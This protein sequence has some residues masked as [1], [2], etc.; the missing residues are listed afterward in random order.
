MFFSFP[1]FVQFC[2]LSL[3]LR[4][5][6]PAALNTLS[7][8]QNISPLAITN[9][10]FFL[11]HLSITGFVFFSHQMTLEIA[12]F[13]LLISFPSP[14]LFFFFFFTSSK[15]LF[16][17]LVFFSFGTYNLRHTFFYRFHCLPRPPYFSFLN[18][19]V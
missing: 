14:Q 18:F 5:L 1:S 16:F 9:I 4:L 3:Y 2:F 17:S 7:T 8:F 13:L 11:H 15:K 19:F 10:F 6:Y 12:N